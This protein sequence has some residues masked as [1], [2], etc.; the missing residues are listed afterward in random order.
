MN[1]N[2]SRRDFLK[3][4]LGTAS[5]LS[6]PTIINYL[7]RS[8]TSS[9]KEFLEIRDGNFYLG[10]EEYMIKGANYLTRD[11]P[12]RMFHKYD[13]EQID[14][15]LEIA[16]EVG[17]NTI[18][19]SL[20]HPYSIGKTKDNWKP[21]HNL[22]IREEY[23]VRFNDFLGLAE[24]HDIK[25]LVNVMS[26]APHAWFE[27]KNHHYAK[28]YLE[29]WLPDFADDERIIA[30]D[31]KN[32]PEIHQAYFDRQGEG[33]KYDIPGFAKETAD[34][35]KELDQN[36]PVTIGLNDTHAEEGEV[37]EHLIG[38]ISDYINHEDFYSF[39]FYVPIKH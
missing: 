4:A 2:V 16:A 27:P 26:Y 38:A 34:T 6:A 23:F 36:H 17:I 35:I 7:G 14:K 24:N 33:N 29:K 18:R 8:S 31:A 1:D 25:I 21:Y 9:D 10:G 11:H 20:M 32:E 30:W 13:P 39:H 19:V 15:E 37:E 12:W 28:K 5:V 3:R 22:D